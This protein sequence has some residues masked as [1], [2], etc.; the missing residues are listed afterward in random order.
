MRRITL[1]E[2]A[3]G[4]PG[5]ELDIRF[6]GDDIT[7]LKVAAEELKLEL[8]R[9]DGLSDIEDDLPFGKQEL[10]LELTPRGRALGFTT[11]SVARQ[12]RNAFEGAIAKRFPRDDE[13]VTI[14]VQL[15]E[16]EATEAAV[17][18]L[19]LR[20]PAGAETPL[21]EVVSFREDAGFARIRRKDD[22]REVAVFAEIDET[23]TKPGT[24][25]HCA[26]TKNNAGRTPAGRATRC[27]PHAPVPCD[28]PGAV[29]WPVPQPTGRCK[30]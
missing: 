13:E 25:I 27:T 22:R 11:E 17:R 6:R 10:I 14:R 23:V 15:P 18:N 3:G 8:Q 9:F 30:R 21:E 16:A 7:E 19:Y 4:P 1:Q 26:H 24:I 29:T 20:S 12:V 2:R 5:R 28:G